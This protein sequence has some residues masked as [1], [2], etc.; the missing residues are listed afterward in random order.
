ML[1]E[2]EEFQVS[3][4]HSLICPEDFYN[5]CKSSEFFI[6]WIPVFSKTSIDFVLHRWS[7]GVF[8]WEVFSLGGS[9]YPG[10]DL[11]EKFI[12]LLRDGYRMEKPKHSPEE[13]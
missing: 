11:N 13:M 12:G 6:V 9:P 5:F 4:K 3:Y 1:M 2:K 8:L 10:V 7:Y